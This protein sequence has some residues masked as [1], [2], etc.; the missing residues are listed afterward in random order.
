M[1]HVTISEKT[2]VESLAL[3]VLVNK[4]IEDNKIYCRE[5]IYQTDCV[6]ENSLEFIESLCEIVGYYD[7][8]D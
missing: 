4:F 3:R 2:I 1:T 7:S 5:S 8:N 6:S